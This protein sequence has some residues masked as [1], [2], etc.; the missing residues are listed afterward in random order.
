M[1]FTEQQIEELHRI[2][3]S[4]VAHVLLM[5]DSAYKKKANHHSVSEIR[6]LIIEHFPKLAKE[7]GNGEFDIAILRFLLRKYIKLREA[8]TEYLEGACMER[9]D[10]Q[11]GNALRSDGWIGGCPI[12]STARPGKYRIVGSPSRSSLFDHIQ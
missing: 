5:K 6:N 4:R 2:V 3:D 10:N 1:P 12:E 9:F 8:D 11:I 7:L